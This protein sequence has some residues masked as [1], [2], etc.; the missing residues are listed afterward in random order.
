M[1]EKAE[2]SI[3]HEELMGALG[4]ERI[5]RE[6]RFDG[7]ILREI[8]NVVILKDDSKP[9]ECQI[10]NFSSGG[11][12][13]ETYQK[14]LSLSEGSSIPVT[15]KIGDRDVYDGDLRIRNISPSK[16]GN[17]IRGEFISAPLDVE[18]IFDIKFI[19]EIENLA[20]EELNSR[21]EAY[22]Q[23]AVS[24]QYK[25]EI[26][27]FRDFLCIVKEFL[28][29][30]EKKIE[31]ERKN[32]GEEIKKSILKFFTEKYS[33]TF[34][35]FVD[36]LYQH[37]KD[38][39]LEKRKLYRLY[40]QRELFP[41]AIESPFG[42]EAF[43]K[44]LGYAGDYECMRILV[45]GIDEGNTLYE[46]FLNHS[47][48]MLKM[49]KMVR[50]RGKYI[51]GKIME[52]YKENETD[53]RKNGCMKVAS[54]ACGPSEELSDIFE[55][56]EFIS[57]ISAPIH[58]YLIDQDDNA[59]SYSSKNLK[60]KIFGKQDSFKL[61]FLHVSIKQIIEETDIVRQIGKIDFAYTMGMMDYMPEKIAGKIINSVFDMLSPGGIMYIGNIRPGVPTSW[62]AEFL[63]DW[64]L[65]YRSPE[66]LLNLASEIKEKGELFVD[67]E[68]LGMNLFLVG[69]KQK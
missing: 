10:K 52:F 64:R 43:F 38:L 68:E 51:R 65:N 25:E 22:T 4:R 5:F 9:L 54:I 50:S 35:Q 34:E 18:K 56:N 30:T 53:W 39:N 62:I 29:D 59:L 6:R 1:E 42:R 26:V 24:S 32:R 58:F 69:R 16:K 23:N 19:S 12:A 33:P 41:I 61:S 49:A 15:I 47:V 7:K 66:T 55:N 46:K 67:S 21:L 14:T 44:P 48:G 31:T 17:I 36:T 57:S 45:R 60:P 2:K 13:V 37:T 11:M 3:P 20:S 28:D 27:R 63:Y 40:T 8:P